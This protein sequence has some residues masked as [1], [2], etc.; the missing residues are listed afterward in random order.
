VICVQATI[1]DGEPFFLDW[2]CLAGRSHGLIFRAGGRVLTKT[3]EKRGKE[4]KRGKKKKG[5]GHGGEKNVC[6]PT[7]QTIAMY[8][9]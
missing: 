3:K 4:E 5:R 6:I 8:S 2:K 7:V 9:K 1:K